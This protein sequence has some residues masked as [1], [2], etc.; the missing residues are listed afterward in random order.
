MSKESDPDYPG[1]SSTAT[2]DDD[3]DNQNNISSDI[4]DGNSKKISSQDIWWLNDLHQY[5]QR[6]QETN[7]YEKTLSV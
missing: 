3:D 5:F 7:P 2:V 4:T 6:I 1:T